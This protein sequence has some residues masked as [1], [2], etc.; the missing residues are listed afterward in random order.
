MEIRLISI[1]LIR[2]YSL[3]TGTAITIPTRAGSVALIII[4]FR[5]YGE[6]Y[7]VISIR[8]N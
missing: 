6:I 2:I 3:Y 5:S 1:I 4:T 8:K 7:I